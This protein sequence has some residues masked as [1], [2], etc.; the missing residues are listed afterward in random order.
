MTVDRVEAAQPIR[1]APLLRHHLSN[2][3][4]LVVIHLGH[5]ATQEYRQVGILIIYRAVR[6]GKHAYDHFYG[7]RQGA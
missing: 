5:V 7:S 3:S 1:S 4:H 6:S 2:N